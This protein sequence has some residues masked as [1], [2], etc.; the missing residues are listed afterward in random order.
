MILQIFLFLPSNQRYI[1]PAV[2][3][4]KWELTDIQS[5]RHMLA[6]LSPS[7]R[8]LSLTTICN[9][10]HTIANGLLGLSALQEVRLTRIFLRLYKPVEERVDKALATF[11]SKHQDVVELEIY[12]IPGQGGAAHQILHLPHLR[13]FRA[14]LEFDSAPDLEFFLQSFASTSSCIQIL[15]LRFKVKSN[16]KEKPR[17]PFKN[18]CHI[19]QCTNLEVLR[20]VGF[21]VELQ[22]DDI[23]IMGQIWRG[24][25]YLGLQV[26]HK[27]HEGIP[28]AWL[29]NFTETFPSTLRRL[30][31]TLNMTQAIPVLAGPTSVF[32]SLRTLDIASGKP[33]V[34]RALKQ[35]L[36]GFLAR[37]C[38][39][40]VELHSNQLLP[41]SNIQEWSEVKRLMNHVHEGR[42][43]AAEP[44]QPKFRYELV[45]WGNGR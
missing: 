36:A 19:L 8:N 1:L 12:Q 9:D 29:F 4:V 27:G 17:V 13:R 20:L 44:S 11:F 41:E 25:E 2:H 10:D 42:V 35:E 38:P 21:L 24:L 45:S 23:R 7:T 3:S 18:I 40:G 39:K 31:I 43:G 34:G 30:A 26:A 37:I 32:P 15:Q 22:E 5:A 28:V 14:S 6:F 33:P 16:P